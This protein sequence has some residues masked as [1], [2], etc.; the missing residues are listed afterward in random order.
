MTAANPR[1]P[2]RVDDPRLETRRVIDADGCL[3]A[4]F[5]GPD[6]QARAEALAAEYEQTYGP[7]WGG[8]ERDALRVPNAAEPSHWRSD[9]RPRGMGL[10][11]HA[12]AVPPPERARRPPVSFAI[13]YIRAHAWLGTVWVV[14]MAVIGDKLMLAIYAA[15][16]IAA[17]LMDDALDGGPQ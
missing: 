1:A 13:A 16:G 3:M 14:P 2:F 10:E 8:G 12:S 9:H 4:R 17:I 7:E 5:N 15:T 6:R 11:R